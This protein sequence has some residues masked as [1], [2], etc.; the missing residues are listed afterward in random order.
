MRPIVIAEAELE[1]L[2]DKAQKWDSLGGEIEK[3]YT[4]TPDGDE[5]PEDE[6]GMGFDEEGYTLVDIG[7][8]A[9]S[10]YGWL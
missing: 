1:E 2:K 7:E 9:A 6:I 5:I 4:T 10:A 8:A 3:L